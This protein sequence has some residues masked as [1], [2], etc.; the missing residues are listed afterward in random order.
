MQSWADIASDS[1]DDEYHPT[2]KVQQEPVEPEP[3]SEEEPE[4]P[5][6]KEYDWPAEPPFTAYVGNLAFSVKDSEELRQG[7]T[8]LLHR[9]FQ[10]QITIVNSRLAIDRQENTSRGFGYLEVETLDD[11]RAY[12]YCTTVL[13]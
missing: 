4:A 12:T 8:D 7:V 5:P 9:R 3:E 1:D 10:T 2:N 6:E 13:S 11:V